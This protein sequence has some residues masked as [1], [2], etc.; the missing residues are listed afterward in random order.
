MGAGGRVLPGEP[1]PTAACR[2]PSRAWGTEAEPGWACGE[3]EQTEQQHAWPLGTV[4]VA[5]V[6]GEARMRSLDLETGR[7]KTDSTAG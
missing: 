4:A 1:T 7:R 5:V 6:L 2:A 3:K